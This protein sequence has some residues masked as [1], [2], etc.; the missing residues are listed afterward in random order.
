MSHT[1]DISDSLTP[2]NNKLRGKVYRIFKR[3]VSIEMMRE[4]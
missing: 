4:I 3:T 1:V 2:G